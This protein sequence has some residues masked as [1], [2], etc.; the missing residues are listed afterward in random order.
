MKM[1]PNCWCG[2]CRREQ[3]HWLNRYFWQWKEHFEELLNQSDSG[4]QTVVP[5]VD[6]IQPEILKALNRIGSSYIMEVG[7][8]HELQ[9]SY[10][11]PQ[12]PWECYCQAAE[13]SLWLIVGA[14]IKEDW[15]G[16]C[17]GLESGDQRFTP[18]QSWRRCLW[19]LE[20]LWL[21]P[22][23]CLGGSFGS[24]RCHGLLDSF[25]PCL[26]RERETCMYSQQEVRHVLS[27]SC[28][29][30]ESL[31]LKQLRVSGSA[32]EQDPPGCIFVEVQ[33]KG[34]WPSHDTNE[35]DMNDSIKAQ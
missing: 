14:Q 4:E 1:W 26:N 28:F 21:F 15:C 23:E 29:C 17:P 24:L 8:E 7:L 34:A 6:D 22:P 31:E 3:N 30:R 32:S 33:V 16:L 9:L 5:A 13:A 10:H 2:T 12:P 35:R 25:S 11:N 19:T 20:S 27:G 18:T